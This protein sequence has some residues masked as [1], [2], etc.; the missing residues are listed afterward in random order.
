M[1]NCVVNPMCMFPA[2][3]GQALGSPF[4][5]IPRAP[6]ATE[7]SGVGR[8]LHHR[9]PRLPRPLASLGVTEP[10]SWGMLQKPAHG[11][12]QFPGR[13]ASASCRPWLRGYLDTWSDTW[14]AEGALA[15]PSTRPLESSA[16]AV[17]LRKN[18]NFFRSIY[19]CRRLE[20]RSWDTRIW[21]PSKLTTWYRETSR[22]PTWVPTDTS[23]IE[24]A[25]LE[26]HSRSTVAM[27]PFSWMCATAFSLTV[28]RINSPQGRTIG[29]LEEG[30]TRYI[31]TYDAA[32][33]RE[34][35][36]SG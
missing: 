4:A 27:P 5:V 15:R 6:R 12:S 26:M 3:G 36:P 17:R 18:R 29:L 10:C 24:P 2:A 8:L 28:T 34:M 31:K 16:A 14:F 9:Q 25:Q 7:E 35:H 11:V 19:R 1:A 13:D 21:T 20:A 22:L 30:K 33:A 23:A 32:G